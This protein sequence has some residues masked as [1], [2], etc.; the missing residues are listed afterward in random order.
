MSQIIGQFM[1]GLSVFLFSYYSIWILV[2]PFL[3]KE[4]FLHKL[5][6]PLEIA[7]IGPLILLI[8]FLISV[9]LFLIKTLSKMK[10]KAT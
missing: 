7:I 9:A 3:D 2:T 10:K 6:L 1:M 5:F 8:I 4:N